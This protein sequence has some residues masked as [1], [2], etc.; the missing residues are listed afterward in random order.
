M[1]ACGGA[2]D[3]DTRP[4]AEIEGQQFTLGDLVILRLDGLGSF[5]EVMNV[6]DTCATVIDNQVRPETLNGEDV[7]LLMGGPVPEDGMVTEPGATVVIDYGV[8]QREYRSPRNPEDYIAASPTSLGT[9]VE[10]RFT[11]EFEVSRDTGDVIR[12][13]DEPAVIEA[14]MIAVPTGILLDNDLR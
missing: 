4:K 7:F 8:E 1:V 2:E 9:Q 3:A 14:S 12:T 6:P 10:F 5:F 13:L 11:I